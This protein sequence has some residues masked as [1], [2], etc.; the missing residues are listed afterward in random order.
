MTLRNRR[1]PFASLF[2]GA[3]PNSSTPV[4]DESTVPTQRFFLNSPLVHE[5]SER[6]AGRLGADRSE[7]QKIERL[8]EVLLQRS[9]SAAERRPV[10]RQVRGRLRRPGVG[11]GKADDEALCEAAP[12]NLPRFKDVLDYLKTR[13]SSRDSV[14]SNLARLHHVADSS[15]RAARRV[16]VADGSSPRCVQ[17]RRI[18]TAGAFEGRNPGRGNAGLRFSAR[19]RRSVSRRRSGRTICIG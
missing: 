7:D 3:D 19:P 15:S 13:P 8:Y 2:D 4:R 9:P 6:I 10:A 12:E 18:R 5:C 16:P 14:R 1:D 11:R 17:T